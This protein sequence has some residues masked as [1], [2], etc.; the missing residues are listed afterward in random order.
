MKI[1]AKI[2]SYV[3]VFFDKYTRL[4]WTFGHHKIRA[5]RRLKFNTL[6]INERLQQVQ[7][8]KLDRKINSKKRRFR[9]S[10]LKTK[11]WKLADYGNAKT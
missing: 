5:L 6:D 9:P 3:T 10:A 2:I 1:V 4:G 7:K 8:I 11:H